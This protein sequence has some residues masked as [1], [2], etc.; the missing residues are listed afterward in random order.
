MV[1]VDTELSALNRC[2]GKELSIEELREALFDLGMELQGVEGNDLRIE[3]TAERHDLTS[4][5]GLGR[6]LKA[7]LG[8]RPGMPEFSAEPFGSSLKVHDTTK[9][10]PFALACV[11]KGLK[12]SDEKIKEIIRVQEKIGSTLLRE[13]RK[14][15][16]GLYPLDKITF[17]IEFTSITPDK[18]KFRPLECPTTLNGREI[19]SRHPTG[20]EY[21]HLCGGWDRFPVFRDAKGVIMS[22]P[23][24]INS[25][26][27]GKIT[28]STTAVFVECTGPEL[29]TV[30]QALDVI[31]TTLADMGGKV[32]SLEC[33]YGSKKIVYPDFTPRE[34]EIDMGFVNKYLGLNLAPKDAGKLLER[35]MYQVKAAKAKSLLIGIPAIRT[36]IWHDVDIADD[37]LRAYGF[38]NIKLTFPN[39]TTIGSMLPVSSFKERIADYMANQGFTEVYTYGLSSSEEQYTMMCV[40]QM[41]HIALANAADKKINMVRTWLLPEAL[42]ALMNNRHNPYPQR[43]FEVGY[44]VIPDAKEDVK[45]RNVLKMS[46]IICNTRATY[47]EIK[48]A[49]D[50]LLGVIGIKAEIRDT[51]HSSFITGRVGEICVG[52][53]R[54]GVIGEIS[55][56]VLS[57][58]GIEMPVAGFEIDVEMLFSCLQ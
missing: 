57:S 31:I 19:L 3:I 53:S 54:L 15:G 40:K 49:L 34:R 30:R 4:T 21:G 11:V 25:H 22:M 20:R 35:M 39:V 38:N 36:D 5:Q 37:V 45:S 9:E 28:E 13:R 14:G 32:F 18:I 29:K 16:I 27:V 50:S 24:I 23:P 7:F 10:W 58:F 52:A 46:C 43:I 26:D 42:K 12:F 1:M 51:E 48:Q 8:I 2:I 56:A 33:A 41:P 55:P 17:P 6:A 47:T 44:V